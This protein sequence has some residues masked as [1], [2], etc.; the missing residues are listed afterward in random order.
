[1]PDS[2]VVITRDQD[3]TAD[4]VVRELLQRHVPVVRFDLAD[5]PERL[6][7][8][9]YLV[10]GRARW[11]GLWQGLHRDVDLSRVRSV[12]CRKPGS[13]E[14]HPQ[15]TAADQQWAVAEA[16]AG[17]GGVLTALRG[18]RWVNHPGRK[19]AAENKALQLAEADRCGL[20]VPESLLTNS[21]QRAREFCRAHPGG[22]IYKPLAAGPGRQDGQRVAL[23]ADTVTA[24]D[25]TEGVARTMHLF[26]ARVPCAYQVRMTVV[27][28]RLFAARIDTPA[29]KRAVDWRAVH[30]HLMY[31]PVD[32][33]PDVA[34]G[35]HRLMDA[36]GLVYAAPDWVVTPEGV[37]TFIGD[38]NPNGQWG[39][40]AQH[41]GMP[42]A[43]AL[44]DEL[45]LETE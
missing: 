29:D 28:R 45:S 33:P 26:Q 32:V 24:E 27:G 39:W 5:V 38:L 10:P 7:Q 40:I 20:V 11:T 36:F 13:Y 19:E 30:D 44:A 16:E 35:V 23:W 3:L 37:W 17:F 43:E 6:T 31:R 41:T 14:L 25:I 2:V 12:W 9:V 21:P 4:L 15:M 18:A 8:A 42:I 1:M 22:V 34:E